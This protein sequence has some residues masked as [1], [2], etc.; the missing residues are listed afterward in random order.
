MSKSSGEGA[1]VAAQETGKSPAFPHTRR[2]RRSDLDVPIRVIVRDSDKTKLHDGRGNG[3]SQ[4]GMAVTA[5]VELKAG[6]YVGIEFTPAYT[7][8]PIR[9]R[10]IV[11][12]RAGYHYGIEF[13]TDNQ[14]E[15]EEVNRLRLMLQILS[16]A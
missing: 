2:W 15:S 10:G 8:T 7:G 1:Q 13:V 16:Y 5:G 9:V 6:D 11:R 12:N 3:L 4:G 14:E